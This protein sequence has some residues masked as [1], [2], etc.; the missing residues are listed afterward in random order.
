[1]ELINKKMFDFD[2]STFIEKKELGHGGFY[3]YL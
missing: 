2:V 3:Y 1:M